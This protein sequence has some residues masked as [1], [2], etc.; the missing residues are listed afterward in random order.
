MGPG[1]GQRLRLG[2]ESLPRLATS[3][4]PVWSGG[5][6]TMRPP[7]AVG[8]AAATSTAVGT[9]GQPDV[10]PY[11]QWMGI[12]EQR[13]MDSD[14]TKRRFW[15]TVALDRHHDLLKTLRGA[16]GLGHSS[17]TTIQL[18]QPGHPEVSEG[19]LELADVVLVDAEVAKHC[20]PHRAGRVR[21]LF[22][23]SQTVI[24]HR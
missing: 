15:S 6:G 12:L 8:A 22:H 20:R 5:L 24:C 7:A 18:G 4:R 1:L 23:R 11:R 17:G 2:L 14:L 10:E 9:R 13:S 3:G 21:A 16:R 19:Q